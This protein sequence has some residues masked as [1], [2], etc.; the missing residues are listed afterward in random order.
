M[1]AE[2]RSRFGVKKRTSVRARQTGSDLRYGRLTEDRL[3]I[4][5][6]ARSIVP[7]SIPHKEGTTRPI[8]TVRA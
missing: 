5:V 6:A 3:G 7:I 1:A 4:L 8:A 2:S